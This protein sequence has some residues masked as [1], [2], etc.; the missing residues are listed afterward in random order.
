MDLKNG[1]VIKCNSKEEA[2]EFIKEAYKQ[3][4][5][6]VN[7]IDGDEEKTR[8]GTGFS[9]I[10]YYLESNKISWSPKD[11]ENNS[12][13]YST[14][15]EKMKTMTKSDLK[16]GMVVELRNGKRFLIVDDLGIGKDSCIN[17]DGLFGYDENLNDVSGFS[18]FDIIKI[19][20]TVG[21]TFKTLFDKEILSLIWERGEKSKLSKEDKKV[22]KKGLKKIQEE[23]KNHENCVG[24][25]FDDNY[26]CLLNEIDAL[27]IDK[28]F[29]D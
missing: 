25:I 7:H 4:F 29:E 1:M 12:I 17:L 13:E 20:K 22:I 16:N 27:E 5:K 21:N 14:L 19:Y 3:G 23:C 10:Y 18:E 6:W 26:Q 28:L 2:Q 9:E 8:W 15:K 11:F 24:C